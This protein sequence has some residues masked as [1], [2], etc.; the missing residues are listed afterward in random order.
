MLAPG[1]EADPEKLG[2]LS[3]I[4]DE[5]SAYW[6]SITGKVSSMNS[7]QVS[8]ELRVKLEEPVAGEIHGGVGNLRGWAVATD[9]I[10]KIEI[11]I[12]D[13]YYS[14]VPYGGARGDV[15]N[16]F[17]DISGS[18]ESGFSM[19]FA[20][21][22]LAAGAHT[23]KAVA[24]DSGGSMKES[25]VSF[26]VVKFEENFIA[27]PN[28]VNLSN[29]SCSVSG[30]EVSVTDAVVSGDPLDMLL[31]WRRAEQGF[32]IV[33]IHGSGAG[34]AMLQQRQAMPASDAAANTETSGSTLKLTLEEPINGE[35]HGGVGNLRG[36]A[37]ASEGIEKIE[38]YIDGSYD[39]DAPYGG[40]RGDVH[41]LRA[42]P[43]RQRTDH[44]GAHPGRARALSGAV[45][46]PRA[47]H[48]Q[49]HDSQQHRVRARS[50]AR[51]AAAA[52][53]ARGAK[54]EKPG[55]GQGRRR[56]ES[57]GRPAEHPPLRG[58]GGALRHHCLGGGATLTLR[59]LLTPHL[60][61]RKLCG[62][63][64][65][66]AVFVTYRFGSQLYQRY[67]KPSVSMVAFV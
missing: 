64:V 51:G 56:G 52:A 37:V 29:A 59:H 14:D 26:S 7:A 35:V 47:R 55:R 34:V 33:E 12:D 58:R 63:V 27:D 41:G 66:P 22:T 65:A 67:P 23:A 49:V 30:D 28:A 18:G 17:P 24:Y 38:I 31:K 62:A 44:A 21:S 3:E 2:R 50:R 1:E 53:A 11:W 10:E 54:Q 39:F 15:G 40:A 19:A 9:G 13:E 43:E 32:E 25:A 4:R 16:A 45:V 42:V 36:W 8:H 6:N 46:G 60:E 20:Y 48:G 5:F 61:L 57:G